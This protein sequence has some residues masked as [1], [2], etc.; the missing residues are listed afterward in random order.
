[1][2]TPRARR[3]FISRTSRFARKEEPPPRPHPATA[4]GRSGC[5]ATD[6]AA[7]AGSP[8]SRRPLRALGGNKVHLCQ[9][10]GA[11]ACAT[12][13]SYRP[14]GAGPSGAPRCLWA[15]APAW[16]RRGPEEGG[17]A[18]CGAGQFLRSRVRLEGRPDLHRLLRG[19]GPSLATAVACGLR[20]LGSPQ[21]GKRT[22]RSSGRGRAGPG[23]RT[24]GSGSAR[25]SLVPPPPLAAPRPPPHR[26]RVPA[27]VSDS[28]SRVPPWPQRG[29]P[30]G[31]QIPAGPAPRAP[32]Q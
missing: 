19:R 4:G 13:H 11:C 2:Q 29:A 5:M 26:V 18:H 22:S 3:Q 6:A 7:S 28:R 30:G 17:A 32:R 1:M 27:R 9:R 23:P 24:D 21:G 12:A 15:A 10:P 25:P 31:L 20:F 14:P 8:P 16:A